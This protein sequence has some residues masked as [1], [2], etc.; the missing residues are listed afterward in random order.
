MAKKMKNFNEDFADQFSDSNYTVKDNII[1]LEPHVGAD[2]V[3]LA[4]A[5]A[6]AKKNMKDDFKELDA[7][8][9]K[10]VKASELEEKPKKIKSTPQLKAMKLAENRSR[11]LRE[12]YYKLCMIDEFDDE[13][14][15]SVTYA[16]SF[17]DAEQIFAS[18]PDLQEY[19]NDENLIYV[20]EMSED[21]YNSYTLNESCKGKDCEDSEDM[22]EEVLLEDGGSDYAQITDAEV[23]AGIEESLEKFNTA[24]ELHEALRNAK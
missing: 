17:G 13:Q 16:N 4:N 22:D 3:G 19:W 12:G 21:D 24:S 2:Y 9:K 1:G 23:F 5:S 7:D 6:H 20:D 10:F 11:L 8:V 15:L 18:E 14:I